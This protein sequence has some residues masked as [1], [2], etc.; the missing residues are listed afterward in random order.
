MA[1]IWK[2]VIL[3]LVGNLNSGF[4]YLITTVRNIARSLL[5][6]IFITFHLM[7]PEVSRKIQSNAKAK[8]KHSFWK[9]IDRLQ[10]KISK[11]GCKKKSKGLI[12]KTSYDKLLAFH[13]VMWR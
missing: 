2:K 12:P 7:S 4:S 11:Q 3:I 10:A 5:C 9:I 6:K 8:K 13:C 1:D